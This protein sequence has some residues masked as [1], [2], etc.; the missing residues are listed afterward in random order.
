MV[1]RLAVVLWLALACALWFVTVDKSWFIETCPE[2]H[3]DA[4]VTEYR[5]LQR[6]FSR[7]VRVAEESFEYFVYSRS[8]CPLPAFEQDS[9][10]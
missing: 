7:R 10:A 3:W 1:L 6:A 5:F 9:L 4:D 8:R 2:C